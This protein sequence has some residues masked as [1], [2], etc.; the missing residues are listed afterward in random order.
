MLLHDVPELTIITPLGPFLSKLI[1]LQTTLRKL[2]KQKQKKRTKKP[3]GILNIPRDLKRVYKNMIHIE[4]SFLQKDSY[5][6][7]SL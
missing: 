7:H 6:M 1:K 4:K 3:T 2:Q 5:I